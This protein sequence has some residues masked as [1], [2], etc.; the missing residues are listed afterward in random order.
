MSLLQIEEPKIGCEDGR[1]LITAGGRIVGE[2][3]VDLEMR[4]DA[5]VDEDALLYLT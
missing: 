3:A 1:G 4:H 2:S 5:G